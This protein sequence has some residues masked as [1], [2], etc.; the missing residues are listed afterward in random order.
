MTTDTPRTGF[1]VRQFPS[2][3]SRDYTLLFVNSVFAAGANWALLLARGW[4]VFEIT[5]SSAAVGVVT[6]AGMAPFVFASHP[7]Q[8][9]VAPFFSINLSL[10]LKFRFSPGSG[11]TRGSASL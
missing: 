7:L 4:L 11:C 8:P 3:A 10:I 2:L 1:L 5:G 6:F 9:S